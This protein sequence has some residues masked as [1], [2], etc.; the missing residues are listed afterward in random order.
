MKHTSYLTTLCITV[1][2]TLIG[3]S[4]CG[5]SK[6]EKPDETIQ[7]LLPD[8][9]AEVSV[10]SLTKTDFKHELVSNGKISARN[11]AEIN[12]KTADVITEVFVRNGDR[13]VKGQRIA[14][15]NTFAL[16]NKLRQAKDALE[17]SKL[18]LQDVLIGQGYHI[19]HFDEVPDE[20][21][22]LAKVKSRFNAAQTNYDMARYTLEKAT[23]TAPISGTIANLF[24][25]PQTMSNPSKPFCSI[26]DMHSLEVSFNVLENE[27]GF[28]K[29]KDAV[30]MV[31]FSMPNLEI[32]GQVIEINPWVDANGMVK[33]KASV[34][35][36]AR[37]VEGMNVRVSA[38]RSAGKQ[39]V[40]PKTAVVLR[41]GKQVLF[42]AVEGKAVWCY[43][44]TG[45]ENATSYTI[46][47]KAL[48][49]GD[50]IIVSGNTN[51]AHESPIKII[52]E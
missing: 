6:K 28:I 42:T 30:K 31:P 9:M 51:L 16:K 10:M 32:K 39:W 18:E 15:L 4:A 8:K 40:V 36:H 26:I 38:F 50:Q 3:L 47:S 41:T 43:V 35:Y 14:I 27:L 21:M 34:N 19:S 37:L 12:F 24:A 25:K 5:S 45:L 49:D 33:V 44:T 52:D 48:K 11:I 23:L 7:E 29:K 1:G 17:Q 22:K 13:V 2:L 46:T 20:V